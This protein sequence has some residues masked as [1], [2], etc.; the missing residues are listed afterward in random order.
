MNYIVL[1]MEWNQSFNIKKMIKK[2]ILL[3]GEIVQIGAVKLDDN[4]QIQDT[5]KIMVSPRY[6]TRMHKK[7]SKLTKISTEE[8]QYGF[9]FPIAFQYFK[10]WC[11]EEFVFLIWGSNDIEML[12][13]NMLLH[14]LDTEWIPQW[15]N[16]QIIF[17]A[18]ITKEGRQISL[19]DAM[20]R[21]GESALEAHDALND[22]RNTARIC[23]HLDML[24]GIA[25]YETFRQQME[26]CGGP[27]KERSKSTKLYAERESAFQ[28]PEFIH[29]YCR[30]YDTDVTCVDFIRQNSEKYIC[31]GKCA[32]GKEFFIR[33]RFTKWPDGNFS[34]VRLL[35]EMDEEKMAYYLKKKR[36]AEEAKSA[37]LQMMM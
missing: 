2:P 37:Y 5:F 28:D 35:Y 1:D 17:D 31:V 9:S 24:Q 19:E 34:V 26:C 20:K 33:F 10:K 11:G 30:S 22:A 23:Q 14:K 36:E 4:Y 3:R 21:I 16:V 7:V 15:Y 12:R 18:Q 27:A 8:L 29:F 13:D 32:D 6:Y 25:E